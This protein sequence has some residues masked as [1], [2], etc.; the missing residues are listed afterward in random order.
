MLAQHQ[1]IMPL[2]L[3]PKFSTAI[4]SVY[5]TVA[6]PLLQDTLCFVIMNRHPCTR[7]RTLEQMHD[8]LSRPTQAAPKVASASHA[9]YAYSML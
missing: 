1:I 2:L 3:P 5:Y 7:L 4:S 6:A 8:T 9:A